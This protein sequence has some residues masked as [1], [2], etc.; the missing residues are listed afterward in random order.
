MK[1]FI[2]RDF[3]LDSEQART[4]F[5]NYA[6]NLPIVDYH[7]HVSPMEIAK[8]RSYE[9]IAQLWLAEDHYKWRLIR[10]NGVDE[11]FVTGN[12][13]DR[14][15]FQCFSEALPKAIGNPLYH[16]T[17]LE[18]KRYF[19]YDGVLN[20]D[21]AE[22][23]WQQC[24]GK[25][26][27]LSVRKILKMSNV[28]SIATTDDPLDD[29][30]AHGLIRED[31]HCGTTVLPTWRP[32]NVVNIGSEGFADYIRRL[33]AVTGIRIHSI[34]QLQ[35]A[36][37]ERMNRFDGMG[38]LAADHGIDEIPFCGTRDRKAAQNAFAKAM[39]LQSVNDAEKWQYQYEMMLFFGREYALRDWV[40]QLHF[41]SIRNVNTLMF[42]CLDKDSGFDCM[43]GAGDPG[44]ITGYLNALNVENMLPKTILYS[45]NPNDDEML[46]SIIGSFQ[47]TE[48][49]GK[50]QH[51]PAWWFNDTKTGMINQLTSLAERSLLGNFIGMVTD[52]RSFVSYVRHEYF[53]RILCNLIGGWMMAGEIPDDVDM[54]GQLVADVSYNN[55]KRYFGF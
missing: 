22:E 36:L 41:G 1:Q 49:R 26:K 38:C 51:G 2:D 8:D 14:E 45:I 47:G 40:M 54:W 6:E 24:N 10:S 25:L 9:N 46:D 20:S 15:K 32:D 31:E 52:S 30:H 19:D 53:R 18:L 55:T 23:V 50:I 48:A 27:T 12:A 35:K 3:L 34:A 21:T 13:S 17:H 42:K 43:G 4:L 16:W 33:D 11:H 44:M 29:L 37:C 28:E 39:D 7:C 5:H